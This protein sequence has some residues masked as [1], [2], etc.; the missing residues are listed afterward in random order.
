MK[1]QRIA[2]TQNNKQKNVSFEKYLTRQNPHQMLV[3]LDTFLEKTVEPFI[4]KYSALYEHADKNN[5]KAE[6]MYDWFQKAGNRLSEFKSKPT[7]IKGFKIFFQINHNLQRYR[8]YKHNQR[9]FEYLSKKGTH[10]M[11]ANP[12]IEQKIEQIRPIIYQAH[13][14]LEN[15]VIIDSVYQG[16]QKNINNGLKNMNLKML[17]P[18]L[19]KKERALVDLDGKS[20]MSMSIFPVD[21]VLSFKERALKVI[22]EYNIGKIS[23]EDF[24]PRIP[25]QFKPSLLEIS[26]HKQ[27]LIDEIKRSEN[28]KRFNIALRN[29]NETDNMPQVT[30]ADVDN[31]YKRIHKRVLKVVSHNA[32]KLRK[33]FDTNNNLHW[34]NADNAQ[35]DK[36]L[37]AQEKANVELWNLIE[38]SKAE[39]KLRAEK[40]NEAD[41]IRYQQYKENLIQNG[42]SMD[43]FPF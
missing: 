4:E 31:A 39:A 42:Q 34:N 26:N 20:M 6:E 28:E 33:M 1:V 14:A 35:A 19:Y 32:V 17:E 22:E 12:E 13:P 29:L 40:M 24:T 23:D 8:K 21:S 11:Y 38:K 16:A 5:Q 2:A 10:W 36:I 30:K 9:E 37:E 25:S 15:S 27:S 7:E 3:N 41:N 43:D 18:E